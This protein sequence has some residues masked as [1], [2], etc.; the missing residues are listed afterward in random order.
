MQLPSES[1]MVGTF[2]MSR[3]TIRQALR[4]LQA[5]GLIFKIPGKGS[6]VSRPKAVQD[7]VSLQGFGEAMI[8]KGY[9][10]FACVVGISRA[11]TDSQAS[12][13]LHIDNADIV[14]IRRIRYLNQEPISLDITYVPSSVGEKLILEDLANK[15]IFL[16]IENEYRIPL[17]KADI[18]IESVL[19]DEGLARLLNIEEGSPILKIDRLT[20]TADHVPIDY[21]HLFYRGDAL[22][23]SLTLQRHSGG[24]HA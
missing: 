16:I 21:E 18:E 14:E 5:D 9:D 20:Y 3:T 7:L 8:P 1:E 19:A 10:T 24:R 2:N 23:Y 17:G 4:D 22:K 15:D 11:V 13:K 6:F 12:R